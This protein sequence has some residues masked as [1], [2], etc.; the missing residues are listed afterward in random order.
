M[1]WWTIQPI[2]CIF[3][4]LTPL[5]AR[6]GRT[7]RPVAHPCSLSNLV[8][9][10]ADMRKDVQSIFMATPHRKQVLMFSATLSKEIRPVCRKFCSDVRSQH[11][12]CNL[13]TNVLS[14]AIVTQ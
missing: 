5:L 9:T 11:T 1:S 14:A 13:H 2:E 12:T 4:C 7:A 3:G 10:L 6:V 8:L